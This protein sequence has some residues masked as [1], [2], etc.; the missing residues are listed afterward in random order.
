[1]KNKIIY[2]IFSGFFLLILSFGFIYAQNGGTI[3]GVVKDKETGSPLIGVNI[4]VKG[5][6]LGAAT[7]ADGFYVITDITPGEYE[8]EVSYI[9]YKV[10]RR[11]GVKVEAG[12]RI[13]L[14]FE[15]ESTELALGQEIVV[16]GKRPLL[17]LDE[18]STV[19]SMSSEDIQ[20]RIVNDAMELVTQQVGVVEQDNEI[21]IRG[22]RSYEV[23][24]LLDG[25][26]VQDPLSGTG[27]GLN[28]SANAIEEIEVISGGFRAEYG[29]AT[30][31]I[32]RV[33]TKTG[34]DKPE[35]FFS[36]KSDH[37]GLFRN[38]SFSFNG[39]QVE[40]NL[41][42]PEPFTSSIFPGVGLDIPG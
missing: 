26:S 13:T 31:G 27:F 29:Q 3:V 12:K 30:S 20:N 16:I 7:D 8:I 28:V 10:I 22:G 37:A 11:T 39:D 5:T 21:H 42:G 1:M 38:R 35:G 4:M 18:T 25:V 15:M 33:K 32:V 40:F 14:N 9:G 19:R 36:Y 2:H 24:Y 41:S 17:E 6:Y 34:G 23:Q